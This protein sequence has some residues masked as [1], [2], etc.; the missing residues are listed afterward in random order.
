[1]YSSSKI[2]FF[3]ILQLF[4]VLKGRIKYDDILTYQPN[5]EILLYLHRI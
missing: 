2:F 5:S 3:Q 4:N 1:M